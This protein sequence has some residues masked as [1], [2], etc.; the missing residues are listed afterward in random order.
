MNY[1]PG[2]GLT[3]GT[4]VLGNTVGQEYPVGSVF[5]LCKLFGTL[6]TPAGSPVG[7]AGQTL[8]NTTTGVVITPTWKGVTIT[9]SISPAD[10]ASGKIISTDRISA[11]SNEYGYFEIYVIRGLTVT[12]TCPSFGKSVAVNTTGETS[13]D[14]SALF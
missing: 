13:I 1:Y 9:A 5:A 6:L 11:S 8:T 12:V 4:A 3:I 2:Q 14:L 10:N 7:E